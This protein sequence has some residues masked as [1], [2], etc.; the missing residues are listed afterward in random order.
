MWYSGIQPKSNILKAKIMMMKLDS[1]DGDWSPSEFGMRDKHTFPG[2]SRGEPVVAREYTGNGTSTGSIEIK[3]SNAEIPGKVSTGNVSSS[4]DI[5]TIGIQVEFENIASSDTVWI[6]S[7]SLTVIRKESQN[8]PQAR[9]MEPNYRYIPRTIQKLWKGEIVHI[10]VMG[11]SIDRGSANPPIYL[12]DEEP[13]SETYKHPLVEGL[14][15][16]KKAG[17]PEV[18]SY[19]GQWRHYFSYAGRRSSA[20]SWS[21]PVV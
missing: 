11:S 15:D 12:Y 16:G 7:P 18:D 5:N 6:F 1:E 2:H 8:L 20:G 17:V 21:L 14:F 19:Y 3:I 9:S 10:M 4:Q 13:A